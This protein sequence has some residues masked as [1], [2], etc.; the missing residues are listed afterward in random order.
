MQVKKI[1]VLAAALFLCSC[2]EN[3]ETSSDSISEAVSEETCI[4][5]TSVSSATEI[6]DETTAREILTE[7]Y[8]VSEESIS[9]SSVMSEISS[10]V[11]TEI[12][13]ETSETTSPPETQT[14]AESSET[15]AYDIRSETVTFS[16]AKTSS[17]EEKPVKVTVPKIATG[18]FTGAKTLENDIASVDISDAASGVVQVS[19]KGSCSNVKV[20][21]TMGDNVYDYG[22]S[23]SAVYPLQSGSGEYNVKVLEN[24]SGKTYAI[25]LDESFSAE[26]SDF[27]PYLLPSQYISFSQ[28]DNCVKKAAELCAGCD[29]DAEKIAA[30]FKYVTDNISYDKQLA[31]SVKSGY[32]PDPDSTLAKGTG[33]CFDY[34]SLFAAMCR[35]QS[36]PTKLVMGYVQGNMYHAWN[37]V[38][39]KETGWVTL[40][41]FIEKNKWNLLDPTFYASADN[42]SDAAEYMSDKDGYSA[43]YYY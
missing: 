11:S 1:A 35:S 42:K 6:I 37:E 12:S 41:L 34:A 38:Y 27:S 14:T 13:E 25:A 4:S 24:I 20:R 32:I 39:T 36:I 16:S 9:E 18:N 7:E 5:V 29:S 3:A 28:S 8:P 31:A 40:D 17:T 23:G 33:I 15:A 22:L 30:I 2:G 21:I 43:V 19:Y 26:V 10:E